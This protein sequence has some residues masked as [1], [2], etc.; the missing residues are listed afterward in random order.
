M[1]GDDEDTGG[2]DD[3]GEEN[4]EVDVEEE[5]EEEDD[6][7]E[8]DDIEKE[9]DPKTGK[10]TLCEPAQATCAWTCHKNYSAWKFTTKMAAHAF[11]DIVSCEHFAR[12][13]LHGNWQEKGPGTPPGTSFC[14]SL[15]RR[16]A[17]GH[18]TRAILC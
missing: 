3:D 9:T 6:E 4:D 18:F 1:D 8:K 11:R 16:N 10:H 7:V 2:D 15:R 12:A 17:H 14:A 5:E 13:I